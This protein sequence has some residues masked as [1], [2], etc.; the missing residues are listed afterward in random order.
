[1]TR[2]ISWAIGAL[3]I[4]TLLLHAY[5]YGTLHYLVSSD[6][7]KISVV[8]A[9]IALW[10]SVR[11]GRATWFFESSIL[12]NG[13][14]SLNAAAQLE[15]HI[16]DLYHWENILVLGGLSGTV[17]GLITITK[18]FLQVIGSDN[19]NA[20]QANGI[21]T[22]G[23]GLALVTTLVGMVGSMLLLLQVHNLRKLTVVHS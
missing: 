11:A 13:S 8:L 5:Q 23:L 12:D 18:N 21:L 9:G 6:T 17:I 1:M 3:I 20:S 14:L 22:S 15:E 16:T 10:Q 7:S 2:T 4:S 19:Y